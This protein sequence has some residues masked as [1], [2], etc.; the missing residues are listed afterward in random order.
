VMENFGRRML[1]ARF[2]SSI[3]QKRL[4]D[5][6][7]KQGRLRGRQILGTSCCCKRVRTVENQ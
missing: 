7:T 4:L 1:L 5:P 3:S 6:K 2:Q